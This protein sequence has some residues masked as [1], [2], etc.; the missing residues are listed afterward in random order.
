MAWYDLE[1]V[2]GADIVLARFDNLEIARLGRI[3]L[4]LHWCG[5]LILGWHLGQA[6]QPCLDIIQ[7]GVDLGF[8]VGFDAADQQDLLI[9]VIEHDDHARDDQKGFRHVQHVRLCNLHR[10]DILDH[11]I[12][13]IAKGP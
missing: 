12:A 2:P 11:V 1:D 5:R 7:Q 4:K 9:D 3:G 13:D 10:L 6:F 8:V